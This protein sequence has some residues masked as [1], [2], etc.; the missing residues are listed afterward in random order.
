MST[1]M[2]S[3]A[4]YL[5]NAL[6]QSVLICAAGWGVARLVRPLGVAAEHRVWVSVLCAQCILPA[7]AA[8]GLAASLQRWMASGNERNGAVTVT[9]GAAQAIGRGGAGVMLLDLAVTMWALVTFAFAM[10]FVVQMWQLRNLRR[11]ASPLTLND[12]DALWMRDSCAQLGIA[13]P[14]LLTS[15]S[16]NT[17][18]TFGFSRP[19]LILPSGFAQ[20]VS[21][22]RLRAALAHELAHATRH[23]ARK[24]VLFRVATLPLAWHPAVHFAMAKIAETRECVCDGLAAG[25]TGSAREY[26]RS[27][28]E[29]ASLLTA[30]RPA[31][32]HAIGLFDANQLE[33]RVLMLNR[34]VFPMARSL[35]VG[36]VAGS[37]VLAM[38]ACTSALAFRMDAPGQPSAVSASDQKKQQGPVRIAPGVAAG[39]VVQKVTPVYPP[40]AKKAHIFGAVV[41]HA[42]IGKTGSIE[43]LD[44]VSGPPE[45]R[46]SALDAVRQWVYKPYLLNGEPVAVDTTITVNYSFSENPPANAPAPGTK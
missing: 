23:D 13:H 18:L 37:G 6:W 2:H 17:P 22:S 4:N 9:V 15:S 12:A 10:R 35:R 43:Q 5:L 33:R 1:A 42:I 30:R 11:D 38:V 8:P 44:V 31:N 24:Q 25:M 46:D 26:A 39:Q 14:E 16:A 27:L 32:A 3:L 45:L 7:C 21:T 20:R 36:L 28:L 34:R 29:L 19:V 41:L 40:E